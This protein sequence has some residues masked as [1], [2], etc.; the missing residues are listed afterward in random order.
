MYLK[1]MVIPSPHKYRYH[2]P[3]A[4]WTHYNSKKLRHLLQVKDMGKWSQVTFKIIT[5]HV[6]WYLWIS[7]RAILKVRTS[8]DLRYVGLLGAN[9]TQ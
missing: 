5:K 2:L 3:L 8:P 6:L 9:S 7:S 4:Q 1:T